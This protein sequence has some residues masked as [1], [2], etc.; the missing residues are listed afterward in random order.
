MTNHNDM[1]KFKT[2]KEF[3]FTCALDFYEVAVAAA[4]EAGEDVLFAGNRKRPMP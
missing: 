4:E 2:I 3:E 1:G